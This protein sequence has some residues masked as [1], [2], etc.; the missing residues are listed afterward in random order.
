MFTSYLPPSTET[1]S[2]LD[3]FFPYASSIRIESTIVNGFHTSR[4]RCCTNGNCSCDADDV[5]AAGAAV[6]AEATFSTEPGP[7]VTAGASS[8]LFL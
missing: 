7:G 8:L 6:E 5:A 3:E 2:Q 4:R 1:G